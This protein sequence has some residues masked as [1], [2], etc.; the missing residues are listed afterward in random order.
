M[1][2]SAVAAWLGDLELRSPEHHAMITEVNRLFGEANSQIT[3]Q[4]KYGGIVVLLDEVLVGGLFAYRDHVSIEFSH[5]AQLS[6]PHQVLVGSGKH[7]RHIQLADP[8]DVS[9]K[10]VAD[11]VRAALD[12]A[13]AIG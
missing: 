3:R 12:R 4:I 11:Y 2:E 8:A 6:D 10:H 9:H 7:R 5:G 1:S 13:A